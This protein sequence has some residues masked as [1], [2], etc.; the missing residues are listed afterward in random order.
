MAVTPGILVGKAADEHR[1]DALPAE[2]AID[3]L[4]KAFEI[5]TDPPDILITSVAALLTC[6][7]NRINEVF[8]LPV[9]CEVTR[10]YK[11]KDE[12]GIRWWPSK[13]S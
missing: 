8:R 4:A 12:Y 1:L 2:G 6:A 3:A 9:D 13:G 5:A 11:G 7:P 10:P